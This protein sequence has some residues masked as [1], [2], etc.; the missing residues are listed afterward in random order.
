MKYKHF[1]L[2]KRY[3]HTA[4]FKHMISFERSMLGTGV[5]DFDRA[6]RW[7]TEKYGWSQDVEIQGEMRSNKRVH[8]EAY[9]P[10]EINPHWAFLSKYNDYRIYVATDQELAFFILSHPQ[11]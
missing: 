6:R 9:E 8:Q 2:D 3:S 1:E 10:G 11:T 4:N 5:L 7:F